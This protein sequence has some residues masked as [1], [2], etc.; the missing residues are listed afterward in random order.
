M[1]ESWRRL[2]TGHAAICSA[3]LAIASATATEAQ[4]R[5]DSNALPKPSGSFSIGRTTYHWIDSSRAETL[6]AGAPQRREVLVDVWYP[7][8]AGTAAPATYL[9]HLSILRQTVGEDSMRRRFAPA[10]PAI[11]RGRLFTHARE[12]A[13]VRCPDRGCPVLLFSHGLG[14]DRAYYTAQYEDLASHGYVVAAIAHPYLINGLVFPDGRLVGLAR[15][16]PNPPPD[17]TIPLWRRQIEDGRVY[18]RSVS[19]VMAGDMRFV[20]DRLIALA[21]DS[22]TPL[23]RQLDLSRVG[24]LGHSL[25]GQSAAHACQLDRRIRACLNQDGL[26]TNL[27]FQRDANGRT[28]DQPFMF[29]GRAPAPTVRAPDSVLAVRQMTRAEEDSLARVRPAEQDALLRD[30]GGGSWRVRL[31]TPEISHLSF[32]DMPILQAIGDTTRTNNAL[33]AMQLTRGYVRAF[34]DK[35][36]RRDASTILDRPRA[37]GIAFVSVESFSG[38]RSP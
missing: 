15:R 14:I 2:S 34:F 21:R 25:G 9:A 8:V 26:N 18:L 31:N 38:K 11:E 36:L 35:L 16:S 19:G 10:Y 28:M 6:I 37:D 24:A 4:E 29:I 1:K 30:V 17:T 12:G 3:I 7:A 32:T 5:S 33:L 13:P 23:F 20:L 27:P 22:S